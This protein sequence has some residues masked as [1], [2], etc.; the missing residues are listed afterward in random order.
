[1][2]LFKLPLLI[3]SLFVATGFSQ[4]TNAKLTVFVDGVNKTGGNIGVYVFNSEKGWPESSDLCFRRVVVPAHT[5]TV[6]VDIP[7]LPTG[8]YAI[9]VGHDS[10]VNHHVDKNWLGKPTEQWGMSNNPHATVRAPAFSKAAF[11]LSG[12]A[13]IHIKLQ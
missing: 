3:L 4:N 11:S 6:T 10:N 12:N 7:D 5:G 2:R 9:A 8:K 13:E 1:M